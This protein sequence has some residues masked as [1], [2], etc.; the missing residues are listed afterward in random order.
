MGERESGRGQGGLKVSG[1]GNAKEPKC[2]LEQDALRDP[3]ESQ[4]GC[5][6]GQRHLESGAEQVFESHLCPGG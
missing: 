4:V 1:W 3:Q 5:P 2:P 6:V